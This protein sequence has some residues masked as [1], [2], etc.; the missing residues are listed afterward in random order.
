MKLRGLLRSFAMRICWIVAHRLNSSSEA[1]NK[2]KG[3]CRSRIERPTRYGYLAG[4]VKICRAVFFKA[5]EILTP[6]AKGVQLA[7]NGYL[8]FC[9]ETRI[10]GWAWDSDHPDR[11]LV[12]EIHVDGAPL[13]QVTADIHREDLKNNGI[14]DGTYGF[15][16]TP[17]ALIDPKSQ[18]ISVVIL[19]TEVYLY[20]AET[21]PVPPGDAV[22]L[23]GRGSARLNWPPIQVDINADSGKLEAMHE[24]VN[25]TWSQ[26]G[27]VEAFWSVLTD[28]TFRTEVFPKHKD[29]TFR[30][31]RSARTASAIRK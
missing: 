24:H 17:A 5:Q 8:D 6:N 13:A 21:V 30:I 11:R 7:I 27:R 26:L 22:F 12:V 10:G 31:A 18:K 9:T 29:E 23:A 20:R 4:H 28:S 1:K 14:G 3:A 25:A 19:G 15:W 16:Y 2:V